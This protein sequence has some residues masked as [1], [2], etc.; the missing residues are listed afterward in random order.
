MK[1]SDR[2]LKVVEWSPEDQ[3][4]IGRCPGLFL[5][6]VDGN[7]EATVF[8]ELCQVVEEWIEIIKQDG[9]PLPPATAG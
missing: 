3:C 9:T 5:G 6:G 7:D 4:Y 1:D 8:K 2:Y